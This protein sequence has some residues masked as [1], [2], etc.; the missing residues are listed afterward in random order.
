MPQLS[1]RELMT[2]IRAVFE[3][4]FAGY[5]GQ[6]WHLSSGRQQQQNDEMGLASSS[7]IFP[8]GTGGIMIV[9]TS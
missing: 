7:R 2:G 8:P 6:L 3:G 9:L 5:S 1:Y 4:S